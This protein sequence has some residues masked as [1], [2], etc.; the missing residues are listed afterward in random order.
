MLRRAV[1]NG[2]KWLKHCPKTNVRTRLENFI[3]QLKFEQFATIWNCFF[4]NDMLTNY[5][6]MQKQKNYNFICEMLSLLI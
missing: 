3:L 6:W 2:T 1:K 4:N 5:C